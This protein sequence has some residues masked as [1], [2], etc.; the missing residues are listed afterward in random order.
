MILFIIGVILFGIGIYL[1]WPIWTQ[2]TILVWRYVLGMLLTC[3][4][5]AFIIYGLFG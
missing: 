3:V 5:A 2:P 4:A 1:V